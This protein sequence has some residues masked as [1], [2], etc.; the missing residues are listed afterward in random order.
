M[1]NTEAISRIFKGTLFPLPGIY[2]L[3]PAHTFAEFLTQHLVVG[4]VRGRFEKLTGK[5]TIAEDLGQSVLEVIIETNS[6]STSNAIRDEDLRSPR[7]FDSEKY[8]SM[9]Y[10]SS[11]MIAELDGDWKVEGNLTIRNITQPVSLA[12]RITGIINDSMG[13]IRVGIQVAARVSR[14]D[15]GLMTDLERENGGIILGKD[16]VITVEA[17]AILQSQYTS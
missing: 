2:T 16:V 7:F 5:L 14:K 9:T 3:E 13:N 8:P 6:V 11:M 10:N 4:H 12:A 15:F 17:E 1:T